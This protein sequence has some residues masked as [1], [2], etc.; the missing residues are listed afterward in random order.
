[1]RDGQGRKRPR[2]PPS[3]CARTVRQRH[4]HLEFRLHE[5]LRRRKNPQRGHLLSR[6]PVASL[7]SNPVGFSSD[8]TPLW[9]VLWPNGVPRKT[10][11]GAARQS[12]ARAT[13]APSEVSRVGREAKVYADVRTNLGAN[14]CDRGTYDSGLQ[15]ADGC[16]VPLLTVRD[17][18][19]H[20][21]LR[22]SL[23]GNES[24]R[25]NQFSPGFQSLNGSMWRNAQSEMRCSPPGESIRCC[26]AH[27]RKACRT[28]QTNVL[29]IR[30][31]RLC[32]SLST[33]VGLRAHDTMLRAVSIVLCDRR[34]A[35]C[36]RAI[37]SY[38]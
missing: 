2:I 1:M 35:G 10:L 16:V 27:L 20:F 37:E 31:L 21:G 15:G 36:M 22:R 24:D 34:I 28:S 29:V 23:M 7:F 19:R 26:P 6:R 3:L 17:D 13:Q 33:G 8:R 14:R 9:P 12:L 4:G 18:E 11:Y 5:R 32:G 25:P 38:C 30:L